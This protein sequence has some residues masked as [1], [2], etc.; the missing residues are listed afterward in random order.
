MVASTSEM[1]PT[2]IRISANCAGPISVCCAPQHHR[3]VGTGPDPLEV[4]D[5]SVCD[6]YEDHFLARPT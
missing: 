3:E 6:L 4:G 1:I 2:L 5:A